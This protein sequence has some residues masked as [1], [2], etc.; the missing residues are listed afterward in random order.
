MSEQALEIRVGDWVLGL[1]PDL[2][3]S[4]SHFRQGHRDGSYTDWLRPLAG[5]DVLQSACYPLVPFS[6][7]IDHGCFT[8]GPHDVALTPNLPPEPHAIHGHGWQRP[9]DVT[10]QHVDRVTMAYDYPAGEWPW[11]Y[12]AEQSVALSEGRVFISLTVENRADEP[13]PVGLGLHPFFPRGGPAAVTMTVAALHETEAGLPVGRDS[14]H[15]TLENFALGRNLPI[16]LDH[17]FDGW[18]G[19]AKIAW[20]D[21]RRMTL[22]ADGLAEHVVVYSPEGK[23]FFCV[24]PVTH[25]TD[26]AN[27]DDRQWGGNTGWRHLEPGGS[28]TLSMALDASWD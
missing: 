6:N 20:A 8:D 19:T 7:R 9:W 13:M 2:G 28:L 22:A 27:R 11:A 17:C 21:G 14:R 16:G 10:A 1:R 23:D 25:M 15:P 24:E 12:G 4:L 18:T 26:A 3:G 5:E